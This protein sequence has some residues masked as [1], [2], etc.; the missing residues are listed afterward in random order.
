M[1]K[2][3]KKNE[4]GNLPAK[5]VKRLEV[6]S[7]GRQPSNPGASSQAKDR[8][9]TSGSSSSA[10]RGGSS[11]GTTPSRGRGGIHDRLR[12]TKP[13]IFHGLK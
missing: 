5:F 12:S 8:G 9:G 6:T 1:T 13:E 3:G 4:L 10:G 7:I 2:L 11:G